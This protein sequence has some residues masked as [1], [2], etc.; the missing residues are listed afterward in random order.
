VKRQ[1]P[2]VRR[3]Y[4]QIQVAP[5]IGAIQFASDATISANLQTRLAMTSNVDSNDFKYIV[6]NKVVYLMGLS[7]QE[8]VQRVTQ[9]IRNSSGVGK[10][11][12][13][14][15]I[16]ANSNTNANSSSADSSSTPSQSTSSSN[17]SGSASSSTAP[18]VTTGA[19]ANS[20]VSFQPVN[21][22]TP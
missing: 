9:V 17:D 1:V 10:L 3:V 16:Q 13:L 11:V 15:E 6:E 8:Q 2:K 18:A 22:A 12:T 19:V 20:D 4:N 21:S 7:T 5:N 14:V